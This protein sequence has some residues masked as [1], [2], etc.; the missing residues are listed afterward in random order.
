M[1]INAVEIDILTGII[2]ID[3]RLTDATTSFTLDVYGH[4]SE[5]MNQESADRMNAYIMAIGNL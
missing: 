5:R 1:Y 4:V 3:N 2:F